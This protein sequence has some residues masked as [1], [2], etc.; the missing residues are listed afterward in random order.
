MSGIST[1]VLDTAQGRPAVD[2][3]VKLFRADRQVGGGT[4]NAEGRCP[5]LLT[6]PLEAGAY[7]LLFDVRARFPD[8]FYPEVRITFI[9]HDPS[10]HHHVPLLIS[11]FGFTTYRGS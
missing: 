3:P 1:H 9:V 11:P 4:T 2:I 10:M 5:A 8:G 6:E 7:Q